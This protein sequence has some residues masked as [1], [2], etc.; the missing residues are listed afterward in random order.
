MFK[1]K[2]LSREDIVQDKEVSLKTAE[3]I[4]SY[5]I[6]PGNIFN[7]HY[8]KEI[9]KIPEDKKVE[10]EKTGRVSFT[11]TTT[12]TVEIQKQDYLESNLPKES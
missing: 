6:D 8:A 11:Y 1:I 9:R 2:I 10:F 12:T 4:Q 5:Q 7:S 3:Q